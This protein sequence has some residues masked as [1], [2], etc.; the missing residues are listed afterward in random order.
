MVIAAETM[1]G[2]SKAEGRLGGGGQTVAREAQKTNAETIAQTINERI[3]KT[4]IGQHGQFDFKQSPSMLAEADTGKAAKK[5][6][7][8]QT[9][10]TK[11]AALV[12]VRLR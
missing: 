7:W 12:V 1:S 8:R 4:T 5:Q 10:A 2:C 6:R 11:A 3:N 9:K